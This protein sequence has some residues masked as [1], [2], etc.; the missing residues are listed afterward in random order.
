[1]GLEMPGVLVEPGFLD[2]PL[3]GPQLTD[4][5]TQEL[6]AMALAAGI[7]E[8]LAAKP[9]PRAPLASVDK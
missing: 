2:N 6:L 5:L 7:A 3:E 1:M 4:P 8:H 9:T